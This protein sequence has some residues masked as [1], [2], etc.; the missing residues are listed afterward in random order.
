METIGQDEVLD[1]ALP[2]VFIESCI[3]IL[4]FRI[5]PHVEAFSHDHHAERIIHFHLHLSVT[6]N[7]VTYSSGS[8]GS[9]QK[10]SI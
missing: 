1:V 5:Y 8:T 2:P 4:A 10:I 6:A 3:A 9:R 7:I